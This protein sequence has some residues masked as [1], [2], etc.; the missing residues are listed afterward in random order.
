MHV[1]FAVYNINDKSFVLQLVL[2]NESLK[3]YYVVSIDVKRV[4]VCFLNLK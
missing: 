1:Q 2:V 4:C 3:N